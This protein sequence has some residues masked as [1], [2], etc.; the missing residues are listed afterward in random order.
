MNIASKNIF[1][2]ISQKKNSEIRVFR[3]SRFFAIRDDLLRRINR[4]LRGLPVIWIFFLR[5]RNNGSNDGENE[6]VDEF[7]FSAAGVLF[8]LCGH[9]RNNESR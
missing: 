6:K 5:Q 2:V 4:E 7:P 3:N 8:Q 1:S 9:E